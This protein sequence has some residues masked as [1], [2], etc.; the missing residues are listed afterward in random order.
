MKAVA[1]NSLILGPAE[2][3]GMG[4]R[5]S[6]MLPLIPLL[7]PSAKA[8]ELDQH[9][10]THTHKHTEPG[11]ISMGVSFDPPKKVVSIEHVLSCFR[12]AQFTDK[13]YRKRN[14]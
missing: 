5:V 11:E 3:F 13:Q 4:Q 7:L 2:S 12:L 9:A 10:V 1:L 6:T 14:T 8:R